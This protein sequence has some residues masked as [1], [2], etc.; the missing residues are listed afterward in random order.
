LAL[1]HLDDLK[2]YAMPSVLVRHKVQ[3]YARWRP[4]FDEHAAT[5]KS[6]GFKGGYLMRSADNPNEIIAYFEVEDLAKAREFAQSANLREVMQ[7]GGVADQP[8]IFFFEQEERIP[9]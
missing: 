8:D 5:R 4:L 1:L 9:G 2:G 3:D 7:N 6:Y